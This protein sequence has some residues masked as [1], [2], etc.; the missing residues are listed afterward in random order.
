MGARRDR[1]LHALQVFVNRKSKPFLKKGCFF[2]LGDHQLCEVLRVAFFSVAE[3]D[4]Y[5]G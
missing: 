4:I 3:F 2:F 1:F 5:T